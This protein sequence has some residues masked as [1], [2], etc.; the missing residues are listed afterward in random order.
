MRVRGLFESFSCNALPIS[1]C[2]DAVSPSS[3]PLNALISFRDERIMPSRGREIVA[4]IPSNESYAEMRK[5]D[6]FLR[7]YSIPSTAVSKEASVL[8]WIFQ[9]AFLSVP[10]LNKACRAAD[11]FCGRAALAL[12]PAESQCRC[13]RRI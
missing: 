8:I 12:R 3:A 11:R 10:F 4:F 7:V 2:C 13:R 5:S 9:T 1:G 6:Y